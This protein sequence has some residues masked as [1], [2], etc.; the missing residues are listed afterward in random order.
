M[1]ML[2]VIVDALYNL[3]GFYVDLG[4][5]FAIL[6][7]ICIGPPEKRKRAAHDALVWRPVNDCGT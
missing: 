2:T 4:L 5:F 7:P 1:L 6:A 3:C